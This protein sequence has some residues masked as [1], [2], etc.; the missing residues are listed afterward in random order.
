MLGFAKTQSL[1]CLIRNMSHV[2]ITCSYPFVMLSIIGLEKI[3]GK[4]KLHV[5]G[6]TTKKLKGTTALYYKLKPLETFLNAVFLHKM[7]FLQP[8]FVN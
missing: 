6:V 8:N 3:D 2:P 5:R 1:T 4:C 7:M